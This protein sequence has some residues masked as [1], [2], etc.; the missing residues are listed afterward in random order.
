[1]RD[2]ILGIFLSL[3][4]ARYRQW[5]EPDSTV[6]FRGATVASGLIQLLGSIALIVYTYL[7]FVQ[8]RLGS[9]TDEALAKGGLDAV[10]VPAVQFG[11]GYIAFLEFAFRPLTLL[12]LYLFLEGAVRLIGAAFIEQILPT[13]PLHLVA[14]AQTRLEQRQAERA[15][16]P[17][18]AD[19]FERGDG[20]LFD[21]RIASCRPKPN[22]DRLMTVSFE[23]VLYEVAGQEAGRPPRRFV[24]L[25]RK[26]PE[27]KVVR[28]IHLYD[29]NE[30]LPRK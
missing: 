20:K 15:L 29:P 2:F 7:N 6:H 18:I 9:M 10:A 27:N 17:L 30:V 1:M 21:L 23:E 22:W 19:K 24:Y 11:M 8:E 12:L 3:L 26:M 14:W 5:W 28:G 13:L 16:G 4:P 25:L